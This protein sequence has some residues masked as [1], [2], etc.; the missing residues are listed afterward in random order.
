EQ[1]EQHQVV[2]INK[3]KLTRV[4]TLVD[5]IEQAGVYGLFDYYADNF[6]FE[7]ENGK[8]SVFAIQRSLNDGS[9]DGRG[10]WPSALN[11]PMAG[12]FGCC[13]FHV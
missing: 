6:L 1:D 13:G 7:S 8:E 11:A 4:V 12:G 5:E 3:D 2:N 9:P 10:S